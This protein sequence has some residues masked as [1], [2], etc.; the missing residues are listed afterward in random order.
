MAPA[1]SRMAWTSVFQ[2]KH[3]KGWRLGYPMH[4]DE[5]TAPSTASTGHK[6]STYCSGD[7]DCPEGRFT[8]VF[9]AAEEADPIVLNWDR[10]L[11][12]QEHGSVKKA[13]V[14]G[15]ELSG[16]TVAHAKQQLAEWRR[17]ACRRGVR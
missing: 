13:C 10:V 12:N 16:I 6:T 9:A 7:E 4:A 2:V 11:G 8:V 15:G 1:G 17:S 3:S 14:L 5:A